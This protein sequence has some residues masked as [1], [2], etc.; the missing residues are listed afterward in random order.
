[1]EECSLYFPGSPSQ[2]SRL[3]KHM[4]QLELCRLCC[5]GL[6]PEVYAIAI[7]QNRHGHWLH[8]LGRCG[9]T[10]KNAELVGWEG[11]QHGLRSSRTE[12][13][14]RGYPFGGDHRKMLSRSLFVIREKKYDKGINA[15]SVCLCTKA[16]DIPLTVRS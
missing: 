7:G 12:A 13:E 3:T 15:D 1:M 9:S 10:S 6:I 4:L 5:T 14:N 16:S 11:G 8:C 2:K